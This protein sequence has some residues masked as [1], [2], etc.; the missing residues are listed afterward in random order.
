[1]TM[2]GNNIGIGTV[3]PA[4][5]FDVAGVSRKQNMLYMNNQLSNCVVCLYKSGTT[6]ASSD[7]NYY[8]FGI[9]SATLRYNVDSTAADHVFYANTNELVRI[10]GNGNVGIGRAPTYRLEVDGQFRA[11]TS[12][13]QGIII[14]NSVATSNN[15][16]AEIYFDKTA[17][18]STLKGAVGV[19]YTRNFFLWVNGS[20]RVNID[21]SG[22][23]GIGT[24][25]PVYKLDV[26]GSLNATNIYQNGT[27]ILPL[28]GGTMSDNINFTTSGKG[29]TWNMNT[30]SAEVAFYSTGD[31]TGLSYLLIKT[32]DNGD[33]PIIFQQLTTER[34]RVHTNGCVGIGTSSPAH[35]LDVNGNANFKLKNDAWY[36]SGDNK[37]RLYFSNSGPTYIK[38]AT[39]MYFRTN[40]TDTDRIKIQTDGHTIVYS[41]LQAVAMYVGTADLNNGMN[42]NTNYLNLFTSAS[43]GF[44]FSQ[45]D[46]DVLMN[47]QSNGNVGIGKLATSPPSL[48]SLLAP[49][50]SG[51]IYVES[52]TTSGGANVGWHAINFNGYY[53]GAE[54][55]VNTGK[56]RWR[57][58]IDQQT[59]LDR[60]CFDTYDGTNITTLMGFNTSGCVGIATSTPSSSFKLDVAGSTRI[61]NILYL[62]NQVNNCVICIYKADNNPL[63]GD[64]NYYGFGVNASMLRYNVDSTAADHAFYANG[65]ELMRIKGTGNVGIGTTAPGFLLDVSGIANFKLK[66]DAWYSSGDNKHRLYFSNS[67]PTY[68]KSASDIYF[69]TND[70]DTDRIKIQADGHTIVYSGFQAAAMYVGTANF[71]N[72]INVGTDMNFFTSSDKGFTFTQL[73]NNTIMKLQYDG[74]VGIGTTGP[75]APLQVSATSATSADTNG[76]YC[77]NPTNSANQHA[78]I[79]ARVA[80]SNAGNPYISLDVNGA[81][82][83]SMGIDNS[84]SRKFKIKNSWVFGG[85][86]YITMDSSGN[87]GMG[88]DTPTVKLHVIGSIYATTSVSWASDRRLKENITPIADAMSIVSKL[89]GYRYT[90]KDEDTGIVHIGLIAQEVEEVLPEVVTY[91]RADDSY[92]ISYGNIAAVLVEA[93]KEQNNTITEQ[94]NIINKQQ[95]EIEGLKQRLER[96]EKIV[97]ALN[98]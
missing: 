62:N 50:G 9:N 12:N 96:L 20:D 45:L 56:N 88:T 67:G 35:L 90:R 71:N 8:G 44:T 13:S 52:G 30:D 77:Y 17:L 81:Y 78:I 64:A 10:K 66:N 6:P 69:R 38:S 85:N 23:V 46:G 92:S 82:G 68:I 98:N 18:S 75:S 83:W 73:N 55:R 42:T 54:R 7:T 3:T 97:L 51:G 41:G 39:D 5:S 2:S 29:I 87:I 60:F 63:T 37:T 14:Q 27:G 89:N 65:T 58:Y 26:S 28:S 86:S 57:M 95:G 93:I 49:S 21:T 84:D 36:S 15:A 72:G 59:T 40:D 74:K 11:F 34:M 79:C 53:N 61:Q 70:T 94:A 25:T 80:G 16:P 1:M 91:H 76:I 19:D 47:I 33:E 32:A 43:K 4:Y 31:A 24:I 48:L 22:N